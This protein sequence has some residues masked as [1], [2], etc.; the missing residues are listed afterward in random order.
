M[1]LQAGQY[2]G[3]VPFSTSLGGI[4]LAKSQHPRSE[5]IPAHYHVNPHF[6]YVVEGS[7][8]E[9]FASQRVECRRGDLLFHPAGFEHQNHFPNEAATCFNV[10]ILPEGLLPGEGL[11]TMHQ[12]QVLTTPRLKGLL[13]SIMQEAEHPDGFSESV[14]AGLTLQLAGLFMREQ[15]PHGLVEPLAVRR[16]KELLRE[17]PHAP[18]LLEMSEAAGLSAAYLCREFKRVTGLTPGEYARQQKVA[19]VCELLA[20]PALTAEEIAFQVG[21]TDASYLTRVFKKVMGTTPGAYRKML[22]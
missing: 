4:I 18:S 14:I 13:R 7:Y 21:F 17:A 11:L 8:K 12:H 2:M 22:R 10:E 9:A 3:Q 1:V 16:V 19:R 20:L 5:V 15:R 6:T